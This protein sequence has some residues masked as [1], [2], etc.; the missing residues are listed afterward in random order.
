MVISCSVGFCLVLILFWI[1]YKFYTRCHFSLIFDRILVTAAITFF[2][3]Q[4]QVINALAG[5]FNCSRIENESYINDYPLEQCTNNSTYSLWRNALV[6]P[7]VC[8]FLLILPAWPLYYM[9]K[10]KYRIFSKE[11]IYKIGFLLNGYSPHTFYWYIFIF[12]WLNL[13]I[14][15]NREFFFLF[16][17]I[18]IIIIIAF[19]NVGSGQTLYQNNGFFILILIC[20]CFRIQMKWKPFITQELNS[21]DLRA[22]MIMIITI[23]GGLFSSV[24]EDSTL[25]TILMVVIILINVYFLVL[26]SKIYFQIQLLLAFGNDSKIFL[27][28]KKQAEKYWS[29]GIFLYC[30]LNYL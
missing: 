5:L 4:P 25:Q 19:G 12:F 20:F 11:V 17:K 6:I 26:F 21:L 7:A 18:A 29:H 14:F 13:M 16:K 1:A 30:F 27:Y 23:F 2:Y 15:E 22:S 24:C 28:L 9:H 10:N 3:F 8:F